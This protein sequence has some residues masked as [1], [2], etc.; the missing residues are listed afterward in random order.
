[1][2]CV[3]GLCCPAG[4]SGVAA[5]GECYACPG[6]TLTAGTCPCCGAHWEHRFGEVVLESSGRLGAVVVTGPARWYAAV[7]GGVVERG[8]GRP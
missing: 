3:R 6:V 7:G 8:E 5:P 1:M 4:H 2:G